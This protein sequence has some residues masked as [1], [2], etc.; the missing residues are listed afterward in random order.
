MSASA[1]PAAAPVGAPLTLQASASCGPGA[2][3]RYSYWYSAVAPAGAAPS[4]VQEQAWTSSESASYPTG[5]WAPGQYLLQVQ[6][7]DGGPGSP[8]A[9][10]QSGVQLISSGT[11]SLPA[12][13]TQPAFPCVAL[14]TQTNVASA[15]LGDPV[16]LSATASCPGNGAPVGYVYWSA[17]VPAP[18]SG[19]VWNLVS[20]WTSSPT[21]SFDT[22]DWAAGNYLLLVWVSDGVWLL[23]Q[24]QQ[25]ADFQLTGS[26]SF[27]VTGITQY[28]SQ[29]Y[30]ED[31][32]EAALQ[33]ALEHENISASQATILGT[34]GVDASVPGIGPGLGGDPY[35]TFVGP[36]DSPGSGSAEPGTY[37]PVVARA[38]TTLGATVLQAGQDITPVQL[39]TDIEEGHP[40]VVWVTASW[41]HHNA[42]TICAQ[43]D[44][45]PW[46]GADEHAVTLVGIGANSVLIDNPLLTS[47]YGDPYLGPG[48]WVPM[49]VFDSVYATYSDMAVVIS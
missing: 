7:T 34:E 44:C 41:E 49:S 3:P 8:Q 17:A 46:A 40:A 37:S 25:E 28:Q 16:T 9:T 39:F 5:G 6:V 12:P 38:A 23:P 2:A 11:T 33:M 43:G 36:P 35:K 42:S 32:E 48:V 22:T 20:G 47:S 18:G 26:G 14:S 13:T 1:S 31:C 15:P 24:L 21:Y 29:A 4:W 10:A 27:Q 30:R 45:F 19:P